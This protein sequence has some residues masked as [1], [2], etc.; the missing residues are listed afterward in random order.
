MA[1]RVSFPAGRTAVLLLLAASIASLTLGVSGARAESMAA[2]SCVV[3]ED[4]TVWCWGSNYGGAL[5]NASVGTE[6]ATPVQVTGLTDAVKVST[7]IGGSCAI[8]SNG[9]AYCWGANDSKQIGNSSIGSNGSVTP[10]E[11]EGLTDVVDISMGMVGACA[12]TGNG[13]LYC[14]GMGTEVP[15]QVATGVRSVSSGVAHYCAV[16]V[17][18]TVGCGGVNFTGALG[19]GT[20]SEDPEPFQLIPGLSGVRSVSANYF[21]TCAVLT[22]GG[23][24][25]W[26]GDL[27]GGVSL[28]GNGPA[29][30]SSFVPV[31]VVGISTATEV[32]TAAIST[33]ARLAGGTVKCW[34]VIDA[35]LSE[36]LEGAL[37]Q[38]ATTPVTKDGLSDVT[39]LIGG[40]FLN[41]CAIRADSTVVCWGINS[42]GSL[43]TGLG[44]QSLVPSG[45]VEGLTGAQDLSA[46]S[47]GACV[48]RSD[49]K[50][51]CWGSNVRGILGGDASAG[52]AWSPRVVAMDGQFTRVAAGHEHACAVKSDGKVWCWGYAF[53]GAVGVSGDSVEAPAEVAGVGDVVDIAAGDKSTCAITSADEVWCWGAIPGD[54][55][56][57]PTPVKV[58]DGTDVQQVA[59]SDRNV[60]LIDGGIVKCWGEN[61]EGQLGDGT[62]NQVSLDDPPATVQGLTGVTSITVGMTYA[63]ASDATATYCWGSDNYGVLG[64]GLDGPS[65]VPAPVSSPVGVSVQLAAANGWNPGRTCAVATT[66]NVYCWGSGFDGGLGNGAVDDSDGPVQVTGLSNAVKVGGGDHFGCALL[67]DGT[68]RCWGRGNEGQLGDGLARLGTWTPTAVAGLSGVKSPDLDDAPVDP[69]PGPEAGPTDQPGPVEVELPVTP[70]KIA[71]ILPPVPVFKTPATLRLDGRYL[72]FSKYALQANGKK[73]KGCPTK[74]SVSVKVA[75][76]KTRFTT[77]VKSKKSGNRCLVTAKVKLPAK[78]SKVKSVTVKFSGTK[79]VKRTVTAKRRA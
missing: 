23:V 33:C 77:K 21:H 61:G 35:D 41:N 43:G 42:E 65:N 63:C 44:S 20:K 30:G 24:K 17:N 16:M 73:G 9:R 68:V 15:G 56:V 79:V 47:R 34:G 31:D 36:D 53:Y 78:A 2:H 7:G 58:Y 6:S 55:T 66:G 12:V 1:L 71:E 74:V 67:S 32:A 3:K 51:A 5:G 70:E 18:G 50:V 75:G 62:T 76:V 60:C 46:S 69:G 39:A 4:A 11:V 8:R 27:G 22:S 48:V 54:G 25:C 28:L 19:N 52:T 29:G 72:V 59:M 10:V 49:G 38:M 13:T 26:G 64:N 37:G 40:T 57:R 45:P 14:W